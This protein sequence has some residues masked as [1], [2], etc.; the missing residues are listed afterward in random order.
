MWIRSNFFPVRINRRNK[1]RNVVNR[2]RLMSR[3]ENK[4]SQI[5]TESENKLIN[6]PS[7]LPERTGT[8][9]EFTTVGW[10]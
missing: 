3:K 8:H 4:L 7:F 9:R 1:P 5:T 2:F 6:K 10:L